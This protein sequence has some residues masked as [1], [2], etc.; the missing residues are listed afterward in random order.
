MTL[1]ERLSEYVRAASPASGSSRFEHDDAAGRD[2]PALPP[3]PGLDAGHLGRRP[4]PEPRRPGRPRPAPSPAPPT[5]WPRSARWPPWPR[6]TA[7]PCW[8]SGTSTGSWA[9]PRSSRRST[10]RS[11]P[12]SRTGPSSSSSRRSSRSP[13]SWRSSSSSS[14]TTCPA[15]TSSTAIARGVAT[16]PGELPE[17]DGLD[18]RA[19][20]GG[21]PDP[22]RGRERL[23]PVAGRAT[24]GSPPRSLWE[25]KTGMLKKSGLLTLHRGGETF[26]DLGGLEALKSFCSRALRPGGPRASG[27]GAS[28]CSAPPGIGQVRLLRRRW[29]TRPGG[30]PWSSTSG[31]LHGFA[32]SGQTESEHPPGAAAR[33][34]D[35]PVRPLRRRD[36]EGAG[37]L[38][39]GPRATRGVSARLFGTLLSWL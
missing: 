26:A 19:R 4:R 22:G 3:E 37:R 2:R 35:G 20:R 28:S 7:R 6:P 36:R 25:L 24:A 1:A 38:V 30:R 11:P 23:Q 15:A 27:R 16:E 14:T 17:G 9:R 32:S 8:C 5:R 18:R 31:T 29:A 10:P 21:R 33:R 13:S 12:A 39:Q 34:R